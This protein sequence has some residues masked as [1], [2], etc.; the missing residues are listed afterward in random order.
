MWTTETLFLD[1]DHFYESVLKDIDGATRLVTVEMY[2]FCWDMLGQKLFQAF[3]RAAA[4]GVEVRLLVDAVGS[5]G[6]IQ[7]LQTMNYH[8][9]IKVK[10][11]NPHPWT[12]SYRNWVNLWPII[13]TFFT[14]LIWVNRR[15]H[16]KVITIDERVSYVG[17]FNVT[18]DH[19]REVHQELA[20]KD[21]GVRLTGWITPL[22]ILSMLRH[23]GIRDYFRYMRKMPKKRFVRFKH[24]DIRL[25]QNFRL[26]RMLYKDFINR[27]KN[28][29][30]RIWLRPGYFLPKRRLVKLLAQAAARGVDVRVLLSRKSD[31]FY[32]A[33]L[34]SG[35]DPFLI[36]HGVRIFHYLPSIT[37]AKNYFIDDWVTI[38]STNMNYRSFM[39]DL[40]VDVR[41]QHPDNRRVLSESF[42]EMC[43][44]AHEVTTSTLEKRPWYERWA[45]QT[46]LIFRYWN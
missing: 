2:I 34:Q 30:H 5:H 18:V 20:W 39:H 31:V 26:R 38:G 46:I 4:R 14:R 9:L 21:V 43:E 7:V 12:F 11:F 3:E 35:N 1:G 19:L 10:V 24:P 42:E 16:R 37:H 6:F 33:L 41:L 40:E 23:W 8:K 13:K 28:A 17:S 32:Y 36:K 22:F 27:I 45:A 29:R 15:N 44:D 25:N